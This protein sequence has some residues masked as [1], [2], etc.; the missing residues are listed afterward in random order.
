[1]K[2]KTQYKINKKEVQ[3]NQETNQIKKATREF[4]ITNCFII[5][6]SLK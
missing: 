4:I 6:I 5:F 3:I 1:M 2:N